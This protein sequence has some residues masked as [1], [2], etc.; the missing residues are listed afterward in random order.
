MEAFRSLIS[1]DLPPV[2]NPIITRG[3]SSPAPELPGYSATWLDSGTSALGL[4]LF[5]AK[6]RRPDITQPEVIIPGYCCPDLVAAAIFAGVTPVVVDIAYGDTA[7]DRES[8]ANALSNKTLALIGMTFLGI[9]ENWTQLLGFL[10]TCHPDIFIIEDNAQWCPDNNSQ[11]VFSADY[12]IFSFGRGK[13]L[14]LLGGGLLCHKDALNKASLQLIQAAS[15]SP[16][17][18]IKFHAYNF[19]L[20]PNFYW[21]L[22]HNPLFTLGKTQY[23]PL[24]R[25]AALDK[26]RGSLLGSNFLV[27][28]QR[29]CQLENQYGL[30]LG[31]LGFN[32]PALQSNR[33]RRLL[34]YPVLCPDNVTRDKL[35]RALTLEGLGAS[36]LY[37][38]P[39][40]DLPGL[41][42][43]I[44]YMGQNPNAGD[45]AQRL[46]TLPL[47]TGVK[48]KHLAKISRIFRKICRE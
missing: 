20:Q 40:I 14:S 9:R 42:P 46:L 1:G 2:G 43:G 45:F 29:D 47:H 30:L 17:Q 26:L 32:Y 24:T 16:L 23:H 44:R 6:A 7:F 48:S 31:E 36:S 35:L 12:V 39:L 18:P 27:Y 4:A 37:Q 8:L 19:L 13:P 21:F 34:R 5:D 28:C 3:T 38:R 22:N 11:D 10:Q 33:R 41:P 25:I 15:E